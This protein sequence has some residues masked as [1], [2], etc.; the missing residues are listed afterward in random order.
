[1]K[2]VPS[3]ELLG[4]PKR[5]EQFMSKVRN[6]ERELAGRKLIIETGHLAQQTNGSCTV[7]Y[8]DTVVLATVV[9]NREPREEVSY[10]PL[11]VD[12][13]ERLYAAGKIKGSRWIKREGRPTD[14]AV[15]SARLIDR[16]IRPLFNEV[17]RNDIQVIITVLAFDSENDPDIPALIAASTAL[18]ISDIPWNGPIAGVKVGLQDGNFVLDPKREVHETGGFD[19][20]VA[21]TEERVIMIEAKAVEISEEKMLEAIKFA[22]GHLK[23]VNDFILEIQKSVG[24]PK[25]EALGLKSFNAETKQRQNQAE[26]KVKDFINAN[27][28][29]TLF[30]QDVTTKIGRK[31]AIYNL[32]DKLKLE[33]EQAGFEAEVVKT[34]LEFFKVEVEK[35][36]TKEILENNRRLEG[37]KLNEIR[38]LDIQVGFLPRT[39]GSALFNRGETQV[40]SVV[41]LGAPGAEQFLDT[42]EESGKKRYFHHYN[43]PPYSVG[44]VRP[45]RSTSRRETGHGALAEKALLPVIPEREK[46]PYTIRVVSEVLGSN[47]SSSMAAV[48]GSSLSLMDAGVP[49]KKPVAGIAMG[50]ASKLDEQGNIKNY[51]I[52]TDIQ[53]LEDGLGG[54]DFKI[55]GTDTGITD[56]Q[57]DT[58][59]TGLPDK[60]IAETLDQ[61]KKA[62][63]E[64][65]TAMN[66]IIAK[67]R[68][69]LSPYAPRIET[70]K[71]NPEFIR[72]IIGPGGKVINKI[73]EETGVQIDIE[74]DGTVFVCSP[75]P[76][77]MKKAV[78]WIQDLTHEVVAGEIFKGKVTRVL[79]FGAF[80]EILPGQEGMIHISELAPFRV[81]KVTDVVN[82]GDIVPVKV[83]QIDDQGRINLSLKAIP[84]NGFS[85]KAK[86][87]ARSGPS[88]GFTDKPSTRGRKPSSQIRRT[89]RAR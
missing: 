86:P 20:T 30:T 47:G 28:Q 38:P 84:D 26:T 79:D 59:T 27:L 66:K 63:L 2:I 29:K 60:L 45:M 78:K 7:R 74:D 19:L 67:P 58:K 44:E 85:E 32:E 64:L 16:A 54:M 3:L 83:I 37:R 55:A 50:L 88:G 69:E 68:P 77:G 6:F 11:M 49:I 71:V 73:I 17:I 53:D 65:L 81:D 87:Q 75:E 35:L 34:A 10:F 5:K 14:E 22:Q 62:R 41:T 46:F 40:L 1:M 9:M 12:Y 24:I 25:N 57:L 33:L 21:G 70:L 43:F 82:I 18:M 51:K 42:M 13:E 89:N 72:N 56:V 31:Q 23:E 36:V 4:Q 61:A 80:V 15:I 76:E 52:L 8:G 39:H 48:C